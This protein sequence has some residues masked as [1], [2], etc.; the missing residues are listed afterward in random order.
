[1][2]KYILFFNFMFQ[3][4]LS[5]AQQTKIETDRLGQTLTPYTTP[6]KWF[7]TEVGFQKQTYRFQ[8]VL[9]DVYFQ[10]PSLLTKVGI[11]NRFEIRLLT[12]F[13]Y[14]DEENINRNVVYKGLN[15]TQIG[16]KFNFLKENGII[17]KTSI[18]AHYKL[19]A[20]NTNAIGRDSTNGGNIRLPC[21]IRFQKTFTLV[22]ILA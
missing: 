20:L 16:G 18:I 12:E 15:N 11:G 19:N 13:A 1:M 17:P 8:P 2:K 22:I 7:Q 21:F 9:K 10:A 4:I 6:N 3:F 5:F 14:V